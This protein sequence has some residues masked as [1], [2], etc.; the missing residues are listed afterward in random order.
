MS[1]SEY[2]KK[3]LNLE[4][5]SHASPYK[6][7][8]MDGSSFE[9]DGAMTNELYQK[10]WCVHFADQIYTLASYRPGEISVIRSS[11]DSRSHQ[12]DY[13]KSLHSGRHNEVIDFDEAVGVYKPTGVFICRVISTTDEAN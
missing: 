12:D 11:A 1:I 10:V 7:F 3:E 13:Y 2:L 8:Q 4:V 9:I 6:G 5:K